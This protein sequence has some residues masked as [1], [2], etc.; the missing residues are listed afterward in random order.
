MMNECIAEAK[1]EMTPLERTIKRLAELAK[2]YRY[3]LLAAFICGM[4]AYF[5]VFTNKYINHDEVE[6]LFGKGATISSGRWA[7]A[8]TSYFLPDVSMPWI[9]GVMTVVLWAISVCII[10][11]V[12]EI[13]ST[14]LQIVLA[15]V[16]TTLSVERI[17]FAY[18]FTAVPY[19]IAAFLMVLSIYI[20]TEDSASLSPQLRFIL[21]A[22]LV[23]FSMGIY[24]AYISIASSLYLVYL[25]KLVLQNETKW[26]EI[27]HFLLRCIALAITA[28]ALYFAINRIVLDVTGTEYSSYAERSV[29]VNVIFGLQA[30]NAMFKDCINNQFIR[31][32]PSELSSV[33]HKILFV[34]AA[35]D[36]VIALFRCKSWI[37][38]AMLAVFVYLIP[39]S[40]NCLLII[41]PS[42]HPVEYLS[43]GTL[44]VALTLIFDEIELKKK[45]LKDAAAVLLA[46]IVIDNIYFANMISLKQDLL[47]EEVYAY[48]STLTSRI[49][50]TEGFDE[51]SKIVLV[52]NPTSG[53][54]TVEDYLDTDASV[55]VAIRNELVT[56]SS[57]AK[58][59]RYYLGMN[60]DI[61]QPGDLSGNKQV[62]E[63]YNA[64]QVY[65]ES[66]SICKVGEVIIVRLDQIEW[67]AVYD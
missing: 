1:N 44:Y 14:I 7:L 58:L 49:K 67:E 32:I 57:K 10:I 34:L 52:M 42:P 64:M 43:I 63:T 25:I 53:F 31:I 66:G 11:R 61:I 29:N 6:Y 27:L 9:Y 36:L 19:A 22:V 62:S 12:Y 59:L 5:C 24:Q 46:I 33:L 4:T 55:L 39:I 2:K 20:F 47:Y 15:A 28:V 51:T 30:A 45:I 13:K 23:C 38:R 50:Q 37:K 54:A 56:I 3:P 65:P 60:Y 26:K 40:I 21:S 18:M 17:T 8:L 35:F 16:L 41:S 48:Y